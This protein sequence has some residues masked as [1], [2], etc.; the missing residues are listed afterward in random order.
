MLSSLSQRLAGH[1][2][3]SGPRT[4]G[5]RRCGGGDRHGACWARCTH[6]AA[7]TGSVGGSLCKVR[8]ERQLIQCPRGRL[9]AVL[10]HTMP[11]WQLQLPLG[12]RSAPEVRA[13]QSCRHCTEHFEA[14]ATPSQQGSPLLQVKLP[15]TCRP[16]V[17]T[18]LGA[19]TL[20][21]GT[22]WQIC[23]A[24]ANGMQRRSAVACKQ[25]ALDGQQQASTSIL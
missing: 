10:L 2:K 18:A 16:H 25:C 15:R 17:Q 1:C 24:V 21:N 4:R 20:A 14:A 6:K 7:G 3:P 9:L 12:S 5:A 22:A 13:H 19:G 11:P 8:I 23:V